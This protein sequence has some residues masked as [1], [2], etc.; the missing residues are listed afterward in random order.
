MKTNIHPTAIVDESAVISETAVIGPFCIVGKNV[1]IGN[2]TVLKNNVYIEMNTT[3]KDNCEFHSGTAVGISPQDKKYN[4]EETFLEIGNN[5]IFR[6]CTTV[7]RGT[8]QDK[9]KTIISN[10]NLFMAYVHI[11]HDCVIGDNNVLANSVNLA[12]HCNIGNYV[13]IG[14]V[15]GVHQF[16][17]VGDYAII[18]GVSRVNKDVPPFSNS[19][20]IPLRVVG[21]N[22]IG[23]QRNE[24][25]ED[26]KKIIKEVYKIFLSPKYNISSALSKIQE[27]FINN[28]YVKVMVEFIKN[29][30]RGIAKFNKI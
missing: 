1:Q 4:N 13:I 17:K 22:K 27:D 21:I 20:G 5:N 23:L 28:K 15:T 8:I 26:D 14:G 29:S 6:E 12:G 16:T 9:S 18:G 25:S 2:N 7:S 11:A 30:K 10:G 19:T 3:I 24:F